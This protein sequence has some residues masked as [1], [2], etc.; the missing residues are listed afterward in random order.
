[1]HSMLNLGSLLARLAGLR[2]EYDECK[3]AG[4]KSEQTAQIVTQLITLLAQAVQTP[5]AKEA[6]SAL[7]EMVQSTWSQVT[8]DPYFTTAIAEY[9]RTRIKVVDDAAI[10]FADSFHEA[11]YSNQF[12]QPGPAVL[13]PTTV[14]DQ[15]PVL[16]DILYRTAQEC[17][18]FSLLIPSSQSVLASQLLFEPEKEGHA[19]APNV[20]ATTMGTTTSSV[21]SP[22]PTVPNLLIP[23][24]QRIFLTQ[25][26]RA[27]HLLAK[28]M[29]FCRW[30]RAALRQRRNTIDQAGNLGLYDPV[31]LSHV[32][33]ML[34]MDT[35][36][37]GN[38]CNQ[39][40]KDASSLVGYV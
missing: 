21:P 2:R 36:K 20:L 24:R 40:S 38:Y 27:R 9:L 5:L 37:A 17:Q 31:A 12:G 23:I 18:S 11:S 30:L 34:M 1:M 7:H 15:V 32:A 19:T 39:L 25:G 14:L 33:S 6:G 26:S 22:F 35:A 8:R 16:L 13:I 28:V 3:R 4:A 10:Q 29:W